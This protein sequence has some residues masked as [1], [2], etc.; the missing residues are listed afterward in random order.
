[1]Y[2]Y[3]TSVMENTVA[4]SEFE[5]GQ[6]VIVLTKNG[7]PIMSGAIEDIRMPQYEGERASL[8]LG[9]RWYHEGEYSFRRA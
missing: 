8:K 4:L 6:G 7:E 5:T 2:G 9:G 3:K 1:M